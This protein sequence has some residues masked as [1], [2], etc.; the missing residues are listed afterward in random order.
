MRTAAGKRSVGPAVLEEGLESVHAFA[1]AASCME[2]SAGILILA[3]ADNE[4]A[5]V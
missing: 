2:R 3:V 4:C 1:E 5:V